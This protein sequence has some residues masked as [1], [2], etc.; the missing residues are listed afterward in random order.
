MRVDHLQLACPPGGEEEARRFFG[1]I[2]G[3]TE[4]EKPRALRGRGGCWFRCGEVELHIGVEE[5]FRPQRKAHPG[6]AVPDL[7]RLAEAL[8]QAGC[9]VRWDESLLPEVR[10][11]FT[12][13]LVGNRIEFLAR[14]SPGG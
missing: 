8:A 12:A 11:F 2:L 13:D 6:I 5:E 4:L 1:T 14:T 9:E 10:R 7:D 3:M